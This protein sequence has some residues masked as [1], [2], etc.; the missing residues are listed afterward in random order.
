MKQR[1]KPQIFVC[2]A[3]PESNKNIAEHPSLIQVDPC[4]NVNCYFGRNKIILSLFP[5]DNVTFEVFKKSRA[6]AFY[7]F[8]QSTKDG[9]KQYFYSQNIHKPD[10]GLA[11]KM[12]GL[13]EK[14]EKAKKD[15]DKVL[16]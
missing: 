13:L 11:I 8:T 16:V 12:A 7:A 9:N 6:L 1:F 14:L 3:D 5:V 4:V 15:K 10:N 2:P